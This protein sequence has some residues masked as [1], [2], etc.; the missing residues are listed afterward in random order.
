V[1][2]NL[3]MPTGTTLLLIDED[4]DRRSM[5][6]QLLREGGYG[7]AAAVNTVAKLGDAV[8]QHKPDAIVISTGQPSRRLLEQ[9]DELKDADRRPVVLFSEDDRSETMQRAIA[10]GVNAYIVLGLSS[11]RVRTAVDLAF[12]NFTQTETLRGKVAEAENALRECKLIERAKGIVMK[13]RQI[14][15]DA[16][17]ALMRDRAMQ[18]AMRIADVAR[19]IVD[20][21]ELLTEASDGKS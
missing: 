8:R 17:Y 12:I 13:Q 1:R 7:I 16:A 14:D 21:T 18:Q 3:N 20:A 15:E 19:T 2:V 11:N 9:I 6:K 10:V 4:G 5:F